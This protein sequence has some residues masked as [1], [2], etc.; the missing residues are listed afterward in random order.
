[1]AKKI[2][3]RTGMQVRD[4]VK[5]ID[6]F[7]KET[8]GALMAGDKVTLRQFGTFELKVRNYRGRNFQKGGTMPAHPYNAPVFVPSPMLEKS[9]SEVPVK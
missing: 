6:E 9:V 4:I 8:S 1:M 3:A 2:A 7:T 5:V